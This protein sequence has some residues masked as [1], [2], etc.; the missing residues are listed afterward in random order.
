MH[1]FLKVQEVEKVYRSGGTDLRVLKGVTLSVEEGE[2]LAIVGPS[3]A[4]KSTLLHLMGFLDR[5]TRGEVLFRGL[6]LSSLSSAAQADVR[7]RRF[8]F[9]FQMHHLLPEL[10]ALE[11][12][13]M[14][15]M[16]R[17][18]IL[19]WFASGPASKRRARALLDRLGLGA[20]L[21]HRPSQLSGGERQ[22]VALARALIGDPEVVFC[23]EPTGNLDA[24][25]SREIQAV[26][27]E[28][29]RETGRT[30]VLV[31]HDPTVAALARRIV[32]LEDGRLV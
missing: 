9:V 7:N 4:G 27:Q 17:L 22:R 23:D 12:A 16:I 20:R 2:I 26:I 10:S 13:A 11:N 5:P 25:T 21:H 19:E 14:P 28:L 30:F 15:L 29:S 18:G 1:S 8:G 3:G 6:T 32:R 31:T 24:A